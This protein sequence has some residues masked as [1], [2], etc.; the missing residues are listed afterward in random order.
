MVKK[1]QHLVVAVLIIL[2]SSSLSSIYVLKATANPVAITFEETYGYLI[3]ENNVSMP[4]ALVNF[5][6]EPSFVEARS[7]DT[8]QPVQYSVRMDALYTFVSPTTQFATIGLACP[9]QWTEYNYELQILQDLS[10]LSYT[11]LSYSEL[12]SENETQTSSWYDL[13]LFTFNC[14]LQSGTPTDISILM[15]LGTRII[16][17]EG[18]Q[19]KYFVATALTWNGT[20]HETIIMNVE[21]PS[22]FQS[23][24]FA[25]DTSLTIVNN[26]PW[27]T[28]TWDLNMSEFEY[29]YVTFI[30]HHND[31]DSE[32]NEFDL[33]NL[34]M[35]GAIGIA[36]S[37]IVILTFFIQRKSTPA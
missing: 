2:L 31:L 18:W 37:G 27:R 36:V 4:E 19:F 16:R 34:P 30:T 11:I 6:I 35:L 13:K 28:A 21:N 1:E 12:V 14:S 7:S 33:S 29:D 25:P 17:N 10:N 5:T 24:L 9:F 26:S 8:T 23:Y 15:N 32:L 3:L 20:T 22:V